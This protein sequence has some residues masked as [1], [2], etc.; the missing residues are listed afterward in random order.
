M[1]EHLPELI[2]AGIDSF[3]I[4]G[5]MKAALY[6]ASVVRAY[7]KAID[8]C[9]RSIEEYEENMPFYLS[10]I[11]KCTYRQYTT[12]FFFGK[13]SEQAQI[14]DSSTYI[15]EYIYLGI[16]SSTENGLAVIEQKNKFYTGDIIEIMKPDGRNIEA[17]VLSIRNEDGFYMESAPHPGQKLFLSLDPGECGVFDILRKKA[18]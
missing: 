6:V 14:Y 1:I 15:Q 13:P 12:G 18:G 8:D 11:S 5:R 17:K 16:V 9:T 3:K 7:R 2:E 4:E 10:E